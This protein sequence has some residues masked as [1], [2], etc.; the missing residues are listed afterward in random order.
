MIQKR[1]IFA[2]QNTKN[3]KKQSHRQ[4]GELSS[5]SSDLAGSTHHQNEN[6][7]D[8]QNFYERTG[9]NFG[10]ASC[11]VTEVPRESLHDKKISEV[12]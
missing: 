4:K 6:S 5:N 3:S 11:V 7:A 1:P 8:S 12:T 9:A 10:G 2:V